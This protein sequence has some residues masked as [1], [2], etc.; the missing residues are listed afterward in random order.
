[1]LE[2]IFNDHPVQCNSMCKD[3]F[4]KTWLLIAPFNLALNSSRNAPSTMS[5]G[6]LFCCPTTLTEKNFLPY[7]LSKSTFF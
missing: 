6:N 3:T 1:M 7:L 2:E 5:L 4:Y